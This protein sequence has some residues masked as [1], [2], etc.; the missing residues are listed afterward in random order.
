MVNSTAAEKSTSLL[1]IRNNLRVCIFDVL[2]SVGLH[3]RK[4]FSILIDGNRGLAWLD[5]TISDA[6]G[7]IILTKAWGAV[8]DT[9]TCV[10]C[11]KLGAEDLEAAVGASLLKEVEK[12]LVAFTN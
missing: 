9:G 1:Q 7:I 11:D 10:L 6:S 3:H 5:N 12:R 2:P 4:E 8:D